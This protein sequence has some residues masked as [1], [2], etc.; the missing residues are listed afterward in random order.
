MPL[1]QYEVHRFRKSTLLLIEQANVIID[2]YLKAGYSL[3]LRQLYYQF[4]SRDLLP[5]TQKNYKMLGNVISKA[6]TGGMVDWNA[7]VD[8][9]RSLRALANWDS[10]ADIMAS[11]H[12]SFRTDRW[13][14]QPNRIECWFEKDALMGV[15]ERAAN[16]LHVPFFSCRGYASDSSIWEAAQ[17]MAADGRPTIVLHFGDHDPSGMDMTRDIRDRLTLF[18]AG[19]VTINR[20]ALN[21][22]Q[23]DHYNPPPNPAK[24]SDARFAEYSLEYGT[25]S[26]ELDALDPKVLGTLVKTAVEDVIDKRAWK[27]SE[28]A[29]EQGR[30]ELGALTEHYTDVVDFMRREDWIWFRLLRETHRGVSSR[31]GRYRAT[32]QLQTLSES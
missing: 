30:A 27:A 22:D 23:V 25:E 7:I 18:R 2:E 32:I 6:R 16:L 26:W 17:R 1:L 8:R 24:E 3:T 14:A 21:M 15:F 9:T 19:D 31:P 13:A 5:N 20:L 29:D 12:H 4:V 28:R 10:P 11:A